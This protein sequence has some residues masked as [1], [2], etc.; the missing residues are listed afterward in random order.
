M[1]HKKAVILRYFDTNNGVVERFLKFID[2]SKDRT[3]DGLFTT[4][5]NVLKEYKIEKKLICQT[6]DGAAVMSGNSNG[7]QA[8]IRAELPSAL[9]VHCFAHKFNLVL[10]Q[11]AKKIPVA[12]RFFKELSG[13]AIFFNN[14]TKRTEA[15]DEFC[16]RRLPSVVSTRW[17]FNGRLTLTVFSELNELKQFFASIVDT[18]N[19]KW[20][21]DDINQA[22]GYLNLLDDGVFLLLLHFYKDFFPECDIIF[23]TLQKKFND[24]LHCRHAI[25]SFKQKLMNFKTNF[26]EFWVTISENIKDKLNAKRNISDVKEYSKKLMEN[27]IDNVLNE[28]EFRFDS[29]IGFHFLNLLDFKQFS[30]FEKKF[31]NDHFN[32]LKEKYS[33]TFDFVALK[34]DLTLIYRISHF[35]ELKN[36]KEFI[37]YC[38]NNDL[39]KSVGEAFKLALLIE[40]IPASSA[41]A[42]RSFSSLKKLKTTIRSSM[43]QQRL[44]NLSLIYI[45]K[46]LLQDLMKKD[47]FFDDVIDIFARK[48][49][50]IEL[51]YKT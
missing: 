37:I 36:I 12:N 31:P 6:Y 27:V 38:K 40:S 39:I 11:S 26:D 47:T 17:E 3:A 46:K 21:S 48:E 42:E 51:N 9:F 30:N 4:V 14:S 15:F 24:I 19:I 20:N 25:S 50:R 35:K 32:S 43:L 45:E 13:L 28:L 44:T 29:L 16:N 10:A 23:Q 34:T 49:R 18:D 33:S 7:L 8:K 5:M 2:V 22:R 41:S 1:L